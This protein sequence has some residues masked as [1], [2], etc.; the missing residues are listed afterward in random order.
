MF[1]K[2]CTII[3]FYKLAKEYLTK[4][5]IENRVYDVIYLFSKGQLWLKKNII[6]SL[7]KLNEIINDF[8]Y[9]SNASSNVI[10]YSK[11]EYY[12]RGLL[13]SSNNDI[14]NN[15]NK[16]IQPDNFDY[17][18][19]I[20]SDY[21]KYKQS[22]CVNKI[23]YKTFTNYMNYE[24]T[25]FK[26][27][28]LTII[29]DEVSYN[30]D[31]CNENYNFYIVNNFINKD[32]LYYFMINMIKI[33]TLISKEEFKYNLII[34]DHNV[35]VQNFD[36]TNEIIF[37]KNG[38]EIIHGKKD[39]VNNINKVNDENIINNDINRKR[40]YSEDDFILT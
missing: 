34:I 28:S 17:D 16:F 40:K 20:Y 10:Y 8:L 31:L 19:I 1:Y 30:L 24:I 7:K 37:L 38:Y 32:F 15:L 22:K 33:S 25:N 18:L 21:S 6:P 27:L 39:F 4:K 35:S 36:E 14:I 3:L 12:N 13:V 9:E 26:F 5:N 29:F 11:M 2:I 23:C